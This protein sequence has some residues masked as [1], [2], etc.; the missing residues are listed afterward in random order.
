M[1][2]TLTALCPRRITA[3]MFIAAAFIFLIA[4]TALPVQ[5]HVLATACVGF[6]LGLSIQDLRSWAAVSLVPGLLPRLALAAGVLVAVI[7][8]LATTII[9]T[10]S[11]VELAA[12]VSL[13]LLAGLL[14]AMG[15][16]GSR[17]AQALAAVVVLF[18]TMP[19]LYASLDLTWIV[20]VS[21]VAGGI[22]CLR[23]FSFVTTPAPCDYAAGLFPPMLAPLQLMA[24]AKFTTMSERERI[25]L[26]LGETTSG[27]VAGLVLLGGFGIA[28][29]VLLALA[30]GLMPPL[31]TV[32]SVL[33]F[34][35]T[36]S[37]LMMPLLRMRR[38]ATRSSILWWGG[39]GQ[40]RN[41][42]IAQLVRRVG[43][44]LGVLMAIHTAAFIAVAA[45]YDQNALALL[46]PLPW[47]CCAGI[48][49]P[50]VDAKLCDAWPWHRPLILAGLVTFGLAFTAF[51][52]WVA[53]DD[54]FC[55]RPCLGP[56]GS[57][58]SYAP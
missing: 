50:L 48:A 21:M 18:A 2:Q 14:G 31:A 22:T 25:S 45:L 10:R 55:S 12:G 9:S 3:R 6:A 57:R 41:D 37:A 23:Y 49:L 47:A 1:I 36:I 33:T 8:V 58:C 27:R 43:V 39:I 17:G 38:Y 46:A 30:D 11:P 34:S 53:F 19:A 29:C 15:G 40:N 35:G 42:L 16:V 28:L 5:G 56:S 13:A 52:C 7:G 26:V 44:D 24:P 32:Q 20:P 4:G 54:L 51:L